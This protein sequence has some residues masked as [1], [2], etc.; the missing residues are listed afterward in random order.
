MSIN[1]YLKNPKTLGEGLKRVKNTFGVVG[2]N[3]SKTLGTRNYKCYGNRYDLNICTSKNNNRESFLSVEVLENGCQFGKNMIGKISGFF[4]SYT[5]EFLYSNGIYGEAHKK[6]TALEKFQK[7][8][9][10]NVLPG[11]ITKVKNDSKL[12]NKRRIIDK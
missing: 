10:G 5:K 9:S 7:D 6:C 1:F 2:E 12:L 4:K 11:F 3:T 8:K